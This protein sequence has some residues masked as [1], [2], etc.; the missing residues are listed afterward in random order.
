MDKVKVVFKVDNVPLSYDNHGN[1]NQFEKIIEC[2][3]WKVG[4]R[5]YTFWLDK[6]FE[7]C[8]S[9]PIENVLYV[10]DLIEKENQDKND[11]KFYC[12]GFNDYNS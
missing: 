1:I 6:E 7:N 5:L 9:I 11:E 4:D 3:S 12:S 2:E 8:V 10:E